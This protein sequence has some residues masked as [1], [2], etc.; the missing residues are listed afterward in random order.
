MSQTRKGSL[1]EALTNIAVGFGVALI[2][3]IIIFP[4]YDVHVPITTDL[5]ITL[6]FTLVSLVRSYLLRRFF[7]ARLARAVSAGN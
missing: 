5:A 7:N 1:F 2:S 6:W 3:Q 4:L